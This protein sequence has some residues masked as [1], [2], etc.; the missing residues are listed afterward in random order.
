V[1]IADRPGPDRED[2]G[3]RGRL[4]AADTDEDACDRER[5]VGVAR[6]DRVKEAVNDLS[7]LRARSVRLI[8]LVGRIVLVRFV[9]ELR[10]DRRERALVER[11]LEYGNSSCS[12]IRTCARSR[13]PISCRKATVPA[14]GDVRSRCRASRRNS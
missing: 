12:S 5:G 13:S 7:R 4:L 10:A 3:D 6:D 11:L 8:R 2:P 14:M 1:D 9:R